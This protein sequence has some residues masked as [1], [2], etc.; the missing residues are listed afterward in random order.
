M[1]KLKQIY[2]NNRITVYTGKY[3]DFDKDVIV[4]ILNSEYPS[5]EQ[6]ARFENEFEITKDLNIEHIQKVLAKKIR[7][8][9]TL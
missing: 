2:R 6:I 9:C 3:L 4:K 8:N 1:E 5:E 7:T